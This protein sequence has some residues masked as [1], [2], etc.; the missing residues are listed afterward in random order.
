MPTSIT[1]SFLVETATPLPHRVLNVNPSFSANILDFKIA[2]IASQT[3]IPHSIC[4][5]HL[6]PLTIFKPERTLWMENSQ[7]SDAGSHHLYESQPRSNSTITSI[8]LPSAS[9]SPSI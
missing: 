1:P 3:P 2:L 5:C 4:S 8:N 9:S 7:R 6:P